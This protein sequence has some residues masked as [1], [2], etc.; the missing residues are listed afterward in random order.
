MPDDHLV[1]IE[2]KLSYQEDLLD[3]LNSIIIR[4]QKEIDSLKRELLLLQ[5]KITTINESTENT[6]MDERPPHY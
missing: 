1:K 5:E 4:Q 3:Q 2:T 6:N